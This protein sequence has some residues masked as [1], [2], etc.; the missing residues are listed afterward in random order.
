MANTDLTAKVKIDGARQ[1]QSQLEDIADAAR[2]AEKPVEIDVDADVRSVLSALDDVT[3]EAKRTGEAAEALGRALGP[4]LAAKADTG[5]IVSEFK[6]MGLT[7]EQIEGNADQLA[8]KLREMSDADVGGK[9]G[10]SLGTARGQLDDLGKSADSSKSVLANMVGNSAQ[11]LGELGGVAGSAGVAFGQMGEYMADALGSGDKLGNVLRNFA[12][13][14]GPVALLAT[15]IGTV[16]GMMAEQAAATQ[17]SED[18]V[19]QFGDAMS[20]TADD[21][22]GLTQSLKSNMDQLRKFDAAGEGFG[23][24][25]QEGLA[26]VGRSIPIVGGLIGDA[27]RNITDLI[28]I[29]DAAGFSMY[30]LGQAMREGGLVGQDWTHVLLDALKAG[31]IT[32]DQYGALSE[33]IATYGKETRTAVQ[34]QEVFNVAVDEAQAILD[35]LTTQTEPLSKMGNE[36][37][38]LMADMSNGNIATQGAAD[39]INALANGLGLT[40]EEVI[41]LAQQQLDENMKAAAEATEQAAA[42]ASEYARVLASTDYR[43]SQVTAVA[44]A[45]TQLGEAQ[46]G[47]LNIAAGTQ[48]AY[49]ELNQSVKDNGFTFDVAT[50]KGRANAEQIQNLYSSL[51]PQLTAAY[52]DAGGSIDTFGQNMDALRTGVFQQLDE[53]TSLSADQINAVIDQLGVFDGSTY[54]SQFELLGTADANAKLALL[55]G[56]LGSLPPLVQQQVALDVIAGDPY[57]A[58]AHIEEALAGHPA[59]VPTAADPSG[60]ESDVHGFATGP[61]PT[62]TVPVDSNTKKAETGIASTTDTAAKTK[63]IVDVSANIGAAIITMAIINAI[64]QAMAPKVMVTADAT[65]A[66]DTIHNVGALRPRVPAVVYVS[67]YPT[68]GEIQQMIGR[69]RIPVDIV[70]GQSIRITGVR[71]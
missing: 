57:A 10:S 4:E 12:A 48:A 32:T 22:L 23:A 60:A 56:V 54:T 52:S 30:D 1:A 47:L 67:D 46:F 66:I 36:W 11:D 51:I 44:D 20:E 50:E 3:S 7:F 64:A 2:D 69:P 24:G 21:A 14:A 45:Y 43:E 65:S 27:G 38:T 16:T 13:V 18:R 17:A 34:N 63:P 6:N 19:Q 49:D 5:S 8:A 62:A 28:P 35:E 53:Q 33:A 71:D 61:Q 39:A 40:Q 70:V 29:M 26:S 59:V 25:I 68:A 9:L 41:K 58:L 31:K 15:V 37:A 42:A 55:Q